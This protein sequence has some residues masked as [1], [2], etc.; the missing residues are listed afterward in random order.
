[1]SIIIA[2]SNRFE[3]SR[4]SRG[5]YPLSSLHVSHLCKYASH[6]KMSSSFKADAAGS[7]RIMNNSA[8]SALCFSPHSHSH[9]RHC[10]MED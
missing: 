2:P 1:M 9:S 6:E 5:L 10:Q 8:E 3:S 7:R 4:V